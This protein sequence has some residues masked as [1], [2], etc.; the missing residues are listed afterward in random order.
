MSRT[1]TRSSGTAHGGG[2]GGSE[3]GDGADG[4]GAGGR[5]GDGG[6]GGAC[7]DAASAQSDDEV[8][9]SR[10]A[11]MSAP[12]YEWEAEEPI[13]AIVDACAPPKPTA[14]TCTPAAFTTDASAIAVA[15]SPSTVCT[16][17]VSSSSA[18]GTP[19]RDPAPVST[20]SPAARPSETDVYPPAAL[21]PER[22]ASSAERLAERPISTAASWLNSTSPTCAASAPSANW[23]TRSRAKARICCCA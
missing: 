20:D 23:P 2:G 11:S 3:G 6:D 5:G 1:S 17:S 14:K 8:K 13:A 22:A 10:I 9:C 18:E 21:A 19:G 4:G 12:R 16:P 7:G 15:S